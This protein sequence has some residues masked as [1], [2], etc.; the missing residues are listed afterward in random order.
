MRKQVLYE[1]ASFALENNNS[2]KETVD[3]PFKT[4]RAGDIVNT[5]WLRGRLLTRAGLVSETKA[6]HASGHIQRDDG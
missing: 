6:V 2:S 3:A 5:E 4:A 1:L